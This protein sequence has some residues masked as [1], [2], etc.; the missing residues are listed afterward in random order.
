MVELKPIT[1]DNAVAL[2]LYEKKGFAVTGAVYD[3]E[4]ELTRTAG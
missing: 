4:V 3:D 2:S 1:E